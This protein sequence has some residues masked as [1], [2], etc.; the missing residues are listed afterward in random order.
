MQESDI[1]PDD[2]EILRR[3]F[4]EM[5]MRNVELEQELLTFK[6]TV[7]DTLLV[8]PNSTRATVKSP[9]SSETLRSLQ[10]F[11]PRLTDSLDKQI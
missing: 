9:K 10:I 5:R 2:T 7:S 4:L 1:I 8:T 3:W 6:N 11:T